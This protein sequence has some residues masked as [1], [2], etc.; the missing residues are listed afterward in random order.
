MGGVLAKFSCICGS[1]H[2]VA[3]KRAMEGLGVA[4]W[5]CTDCGRRF[6]LTHQPPDVFVP[7]YLDP[8][9]RSVEPRETGAANPV[10]RVKNP[11][12]PPAIEFSCRCGASIIAHSWMYGTSI[13]CPS[14]R[15]NI[16]AALRY[17]LR[18]KRFVILPEYPHTAVQG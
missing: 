4:H 17:H 15:S 1:R 16:L 5:A 8:C 9:V 2:S 11:I 14:C 6:V 18:E 10:K 12:P 13:S 7:V 3:W